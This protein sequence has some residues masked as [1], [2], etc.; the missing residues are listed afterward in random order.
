MY[1]Y[2]MMRYNIYAHRHAPSADLLPEIQVVLENKIWRFMDSTG[3]GQRRCIGCLQLATKLQVIF[4]KS[5][6]YY[7]ALLQKR[8]FKISHPMGLR[9]PVLIIHNLLVQIISLRYVQIIVW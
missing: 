6:T 3:I 5:A 9:H 8:L 7:R 2:T 1:V 4:R